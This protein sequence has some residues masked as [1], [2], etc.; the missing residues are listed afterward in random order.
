MHYKQFSYEHSS[1]LHSFVYYR[2]W[3][4][5]VTVL[6]ISFIVLLFAYHIYRRRDQPEAK[7]LQLILLGFVPVSFLFSRMRSIP[8]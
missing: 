7:P 5:S 3:A 8:L 4:N 2:L 6:S 1:L